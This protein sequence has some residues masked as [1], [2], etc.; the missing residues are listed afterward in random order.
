VSIRTA[1]IDKTE[2]KIHYGAG[3]G[4]V[5]DSEPDKEFEEC[6]LKTKVFVA[7]RQPVF[8]IL[9]SLLWTPEEGFFLLEE[10]LERMGNTADYF[11]YPFDKVK[12]ISALEALVVV[13]R[14]VKVRVLLDKKGCF[15]I[16]VQD[17]DMTASMSI[18]DP[19]TIP[20]ALHPIKSNNHFLYHKTT[21]RVVYEQALLDPALLDP[22]LLD[23]RRLKDVLL[24]NER[25][26]L[27]EST[28]A[29]IVIRKNDRFITP[30]V[31]CGL[32]AG[33]FRQY[34]LENKEIEEEVVMVQDLNEHTEIYLINS[35]RKWR[36]VKL[37]IT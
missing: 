23:Q 14:K 21:H 32:L 29:N 3:G 28:I 30:P 31:E 10:H 33:T 6:L 24:W 7:P 22:A 36:P 5:A 26:E 4:I 35:V 8:S 16:E 2:G 37:M 9:E 12:L 20:L 19:K 18:A 27:T 17:L 11:T 13:D 15:K 34:L 25:N 1:F